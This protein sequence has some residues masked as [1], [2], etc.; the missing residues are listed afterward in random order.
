MRAR[1][2]GKAGCRAVEAAESTRQLQPHKATR[3]ETG[4]RGDIREKEQ[5]TGELPAPRSFPTFALDVA[6]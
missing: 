4:M 6:W 2:R 3:G 1:L 5:V